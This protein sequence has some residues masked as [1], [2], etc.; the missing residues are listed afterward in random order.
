L[1]D[2]IT[3]L[4]K[5]ETTLSVIRDETIK[6]PLTVGQIRLD[7]TGAG[8]PDDLFKVILNRYMGQRNVRQDED[9]LIV[10]DRGD[11]AWLRGYCHLL[12]ALAQVGLAYDWQELFDC[13]GHVFFA[14]AETPHEFLKTLKETP[15]QGFFDLG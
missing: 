7:L 11:V 9:L 3:D 12:M 10:F 4:Q 2:L 8:K 5:A 13:T 15:G 1:D 14:K 6:L